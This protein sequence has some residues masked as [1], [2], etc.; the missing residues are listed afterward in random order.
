MADVGVAGS[1]PTTRWLSMP[2]PVSVVAEA[3]W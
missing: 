2:D 1:G 3:P